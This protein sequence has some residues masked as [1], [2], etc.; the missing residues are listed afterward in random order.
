MA[1][2]NRKQYSAIAREDL[3]IRINSSAVNTDSSDSSSS[4]VDQNMIQTWFDSWHDS[5]CTKA[6]S[7]EFS[8]TPDQIEYHARLGDE[9][10]ASRMSNQSVARC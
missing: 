4:N 9:S 2:P 8:S 10:A 1:I 6:E 7:A 3:L 5:H